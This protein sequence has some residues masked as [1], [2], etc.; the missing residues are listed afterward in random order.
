MIL[1]Q[2][3]DNRHTSW[4]EPRYFITI[5][6]LPRGVKQWKTT[7][8]A[9][10]AA[11]QKAVGNTV[12]EETVQTTQ[13]KED[14]DQEGHSQMMAERESHTEKGSHSVKIQKEEAS[15]EKGDHSETGRADHS[16]TVKEI[17]SEEKEGHSERIR[18]EEASAE[19]GDHSETGRADHSETVKE[20]HTATG[21]RA[22]SEIPE[23]RASIKRISATSAMKMKAESTR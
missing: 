10:M 13:V 4:R 17:H 7:E 2:I 23:R 6:N 8:E 21:G 14:S 16:E 22:D 1:Y 9:A 3:Q 20:G 12:T 18:K 5:F 15:A 11:D 19:K